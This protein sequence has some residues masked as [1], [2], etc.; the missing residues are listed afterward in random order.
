M[1]HA[2]TV[3]HYCCESYY[4]ETSRAN[5]RSGCITS[6]PPLLHKINAVMFTTCCSF[7]ITVYCAVHQLPLHMEPTTAQIHTCVAQHLFLCASTAAL[8]GH[9][10]T[11]RLTARAVMTPAV[12]GGKHKQAVL[13]R[14]HTRAGVLHIK[15][16]ATL[17]GSLDDHAVHASG[18]R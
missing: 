12:K 17:A 10:L 7:K 2:R 11:A 5:W 8:L 4:N 9:K 6:D 3:I 13:V 15:W 14:R 18:A 1:S 16:H